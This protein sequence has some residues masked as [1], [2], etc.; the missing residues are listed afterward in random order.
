MYSPAAEEHLRALTARRQ[1]IVIDS[2]V[3]QLTHQPNVETRNR[4][5]MRPNPVATWELRIQDLRVYYDYEEAPNAVVHIRAVG[6][7]WRD[8]VRIAGE[9]IQL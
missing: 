6:E 8:R 2:V 9:E 4:K 1:A 3:R 5:R 7:K